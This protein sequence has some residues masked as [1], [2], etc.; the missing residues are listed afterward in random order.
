MPPV[1][2]PLHFSAVHSVVAFLYFW[3]DFLPDIVGNTKVEYGQ[4]VVKNLS[5]SRQFDT[6][7]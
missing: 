6:S 2:V 3:I 4:T 7:K 1:V 5:L